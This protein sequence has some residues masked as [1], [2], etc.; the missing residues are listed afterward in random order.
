MNDIVSHLPGAVP[1][2]TRYSAIPLSLSRNAVHATDILDCVKN[3]FSL[4]IITGGC[5]WEISPM[6]GGEESRMNPSDE[7]TLDNPTP[8]VALTYSKGNIIGWTL[9]YSI[10]N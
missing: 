2:Q 4:S 5:L 8:L 6:I 1:T 7:D 3:C 10:V 9:F